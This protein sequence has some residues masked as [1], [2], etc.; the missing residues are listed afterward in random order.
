MIGYDPVKSVLDDA[1]GE[2]FLDKRAL[3]KLHAWERLGYKNIPWRKP[4]KYERIALPLDI[5]LCPLRWDEMTMGKS[6]VKFLEYAVSGAATVATNCPVYNKTIVHGETGLLA[7]SPSEMI[8]CVALLMRHE[9][10]RQRL[11][12][13]AQQYVREERGAKQM[14]EEWGNAITA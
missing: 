5:A 4:A 10:L 13:N 7:G 8:D 2:E 11:A 1:G 14:R 6:D 3:E 12:A 9:D